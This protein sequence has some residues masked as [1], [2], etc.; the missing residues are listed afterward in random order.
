[1]IAQPFWLGLAQYQARSINLAF[2][3]SDP[4]Y[5]YEHTPSMEQ[6]MMQI[7]PEYVVEDYNPNTFANAPAQYNWAIAQWT[8]FLD[9]LA[10]HCQ[11]I[12]RI[13]MQR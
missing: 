3:L 10:Q 6:V 12:E 13:A 8:M 9:Y 4:Q 7:N 2:V 11:V 5:G 1:M